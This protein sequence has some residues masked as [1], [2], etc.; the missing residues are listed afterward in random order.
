MIFGIEIAFFLTMKSKEKKNRIIH[1]SILFILVAI[2][3]H[4]M[5]RG[6]IIG[7]VFALTVSLV[8]KLYKNR[9]KILKERKYLM[10]VT[11]VSIIFIVVGILFCNKYVGSISL[12]PVT[13]AKR[14]N[15]IRINLIYSG[16]HFLGEKANI[17][18][19]I[20]AGNSTYYLKENNIYYTHRMYSFHNFWLE[21][22]VEF[23]II[24]FMFYVVV[25]FSTMKKLLLSA[26]GK[27]KHYNYLLF[28]F[29]LAFVIAGIS[30]SS[31]LTREW[32]LFMYAFSFL[33]INK[34]GICEKTDSEE[35]NAL[36]IATYFPPMNGIG[37]VRVTKFA[38]Y[39]KKYGWNANVITIDESMIDFKDNSLLNDI[40]NVNVYRLKFNKKHKDISIDFYKAL[41]K[42]MRK[43]LREK[44]YDIVYV[45]CGP[46][47]TMPIGKYLYNQYGLDY[48]IDM[49][50]PWSTQTQSNSKS[51]KQ[52][53]KKL[54]KNIVEIYSF[55]SAKKIITIND[56]MS[57][58]YRLEYK[59][60]KDKIKTISN[61]FDLSDYIN[62]KP[63]KMSGF[64][65]VY[66]G[67][68]ETAAGFRNPKSLF[69]AI[70][71]CLNEKKDINF[72]HVGDKENKIIEMAKSE[73]I[74]DN[75]VFV[76]KKPFN[77]TISY[78][79]SADL[80]IVI[81]SGNKN[82]QTGKI[83][84][85]IC[86]NV[87]ILVLASKNTEIAKVCKNFDN[88]YFA[89]TNNVDEIKK[90]IAKIFQGKTKKNNVMKLKNS[91]YNREKLTGL[92]V[93]VFDE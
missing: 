57:E 77:T 44:Q 79:K 33:L 53:V 72:V 76:G 66:A 67:K 36:M 80:L 65:V 15:D 59:R 41:K 68:F 91:D 19:G 38:K 17:I 29:W 21:I 23:G 2:F 39:L 16:I 84:D 24:I 30:S 73:K 62:I 70:S 31:M 45:T 74:Y 93:D 5:S 35:K 32:L 47:F 9:E 20:G 54:I 1:G 48:V 90:V 50:D 63:R 87:P 49:R 75:C 78:C 81:G 55:S 71:K 12:T 3:I 42:N 56:K 10:L 52:K 51:F 6:C 13:K 7:L 28:Y 83:F 18:T 34:K 88:I 25:Y 14:S 85:Y 26:Y 82:E 46:F 27:M 92:L 11:S 69:T 89:S 61:G 37:T 60:Y 4:I 8:A 22:L 40:E 86:C 43:I 64:N 58:E